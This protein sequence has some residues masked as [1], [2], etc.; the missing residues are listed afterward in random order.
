MGPRCRWRCVMASILTEHTTIFTATLMLRVWWARIVGA[1]PSW[2]KTW[3]Y[4]RPIV[5]GSPHNIVHE[6]HI[7][8]HNVISF[9]SL[10]MICR[11]QLTETWVS[12]IHPTHTNISGKLITQMLFYRCYHDVT[13]CYQLWTTSECWTS[14]AKCNHGHLSWNR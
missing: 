4:G 8:S 11:G 2:S 10:E 5:P 12:Q 13:R 9:N 6:S 7:T 14:A 1:T 3:R